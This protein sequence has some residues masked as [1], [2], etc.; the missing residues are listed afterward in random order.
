MA[1]QR[2]L[3]VAP[4]SR[5]PALIDLQA[6]LRAVRVSMSLL[7]GLRSLKGA[8]NGHG[9]TSSNG[10]CNDD[11]ASSQEVFDDEGKK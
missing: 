11:D 3:I 7:R 2:S 6:T 10:S 5:Y 4:L 1:R 8:A 9:S